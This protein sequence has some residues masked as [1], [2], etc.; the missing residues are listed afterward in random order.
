MRSVFLTTPSRTLPSSPNWNR[1]TAWFLSPRYGNPWNTLW[2]QSSLRAW[3]SARP[4]LVV[5]LM[6]KSSLA[7]DLLI[8]SEN[9]LSSYFSGSVRGSPIRSA[10]SY[11]LMGT[12]GDSSESVPMQREPR[13]AAQ[14]MS[15]GIPREILRSAS[16]GDRSKGSLVLF[17][18]FLMAEISFRASA[19]GMSLESAISATLNQ[20]HP[21]T[22]FSILP[23]ESSR[24]QRM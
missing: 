18:P 21:G 7:M 17:T 23:L 1:G 2:P 15:T 12:G 6:K 13:P 22:A 5:V 11:M 19:R 4:A 20:M 14:S 10:M 16:N 8:S 3:F 9:L 24:L